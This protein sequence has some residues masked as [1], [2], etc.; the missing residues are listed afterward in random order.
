M[1]NTLDF[2]DITS[3]VFDLDNTLYPR[4]TDLFSQIDKKMTAYVQNLLSLPRDEARKVQKDYYRDYGTTLNGLMK[5]HGID[6][7]DFLEKVHDIDYSWIKPHPELGEAIRTLPGRKF[8]F[9]NGDVGHAERTATAL[10]ILDHF[11]EI[12]DILAADLTPKPAAET[13]DR[14][15]SLHSID[16]ASAAM[17]EDLPRNLTVPKSLGMR[18]VL[19]VPHNMDE[20]LGEVWE[21][22]GKD[23]DHIDYVTDDL[24]G[25][26]Q[27]Y[28]DAR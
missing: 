25:F 16:G 22:E 11:D 8:I 3:W 4:H 6:P 5:I 2:D 18:T 1:P 21:E 27:T 7:N 13:Y 28:L 12:F 9:T 20:A 24:A 26:L 14:F 23:G 19:I 17:F 10:G 15:L